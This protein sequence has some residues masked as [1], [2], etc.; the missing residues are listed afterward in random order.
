VL[1]RC[2]AWIRELKEETT[3]AGRRHCGCPALHWHVD[4][5]PAAAEG[6]VKKVKKV[7]KSKKSDKMGIGRGLRLWSINVKKGKK[8]IRQT[9]KG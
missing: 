5:R 7:K 6:A 2:Q 8:C 1:G 9:G 4:P 3:P